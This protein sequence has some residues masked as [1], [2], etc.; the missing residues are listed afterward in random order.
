[1]PWWV[2]ARAKISLVTPTSAGRLRYDVPSVSTRSPLKAR[3]ACCTS[4]GS[5]ASSA[6]ESAAASTSAGSVPRNP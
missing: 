1:M 3:A 6:S 4:R 5:A 2:N